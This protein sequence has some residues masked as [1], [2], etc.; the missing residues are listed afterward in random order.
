MTKRQWLEGISKEDAVFR[1]YEKFYFHMTCLECV[2]YKADK[3]GKYK[4]TSDMQDSCLD[5]FEDWLNE[6]MD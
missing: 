3:Y 1:M 6:E 5:Q 4:C 2:F